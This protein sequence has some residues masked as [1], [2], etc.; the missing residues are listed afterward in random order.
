MFIIAGVNSWSPAL[1]DSPVFFTAGI[2]VFQASIHV[3]HIQKTLLIFFLRNRENPLRFPPPSLPSEGLFG[4]NPPPLWAEFN[5]VLFNFQALD[6]AN[7]F[8]LKLINAFW[9]C[10]LFSTGLDAC[11]I[12]IFFLCGVV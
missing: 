2:S 1:S 10:C 5:M 9:C 6:V 4:L 12:N 3:V 7:D 11:R 8:N